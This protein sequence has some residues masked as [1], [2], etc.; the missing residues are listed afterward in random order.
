MLPDAKD[1]NYWKTSRSSPS[2]WIQR[3]KQEIE[4]VG[5]KVLAEAF[6]REEDSGRAAYMLGFELDGERFKVVWP[7]L[8]SNDDES[9][10]R[11]QAATM[12]YHD[13]KQRCI[14]SRVL[15]A[16]QAFFSYLLLPDGMSVSDL[17]LPEIAS[18]VPRYFRSQMLPDGRGGEA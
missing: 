4:G 17:S 16:R 5:G 1:M 8:P 7:V 18:R 6:G 14:S 15:G 9:A 12:L 10:A 2:T 3:A 11:R 13:V